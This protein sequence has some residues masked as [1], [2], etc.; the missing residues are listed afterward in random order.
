MIRRIIGRPVTVFMLIAGLCLLGAVSFRQLPI[1]LFPNTEL[2]QLIVYIS[3]PQN[4]VPS[5]VEHYAVMQHKV[6]SS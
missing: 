3:G 6:K 1:E 2:P 5:Y 4:A